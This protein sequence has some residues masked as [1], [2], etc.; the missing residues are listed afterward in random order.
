M[1]IQPPLQQ[2]M[3]ALRAVNLKELERAEELGRD[4][5]FKQAVEFLKKI[6]D[7][8]IQVIENAELLRISANTEQRITNLANNVNE[9]VK[10]IREFVLR[11]NEANAPDQHRQINETVSKLYQED[12]DFLPPLIERVNILK[13]NPSEVEN[14]VAQALQSIKDIEKIKSEAQKTKENIDF[15]VK[16]VRDALGKEGALISATDFENQAEEHKGLAKWWFRASVVSIVITVVLI[17][18]LFSGRFPSLNLT[19]VGNDYPRIAQVTVFK[20]VLLSIAYLL[21]YQSLKN[22]KINQH[23]YVLNKHRQLTLSVYPLMAKATNDQEQ[24]NIIVAQA[25]KAIFDPGTTGYLD[26]DDNPNPVNLT[27]IIN[28]VVDKN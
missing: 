3:D 2:A 6:L 21:V 27:E 1:I 4:Y 11:G 26:G 16:E 12:L 18:T 13:L 24:S 23:L 8:L 7:D 17:L 14:Q 9:N 19:K 28:K 20:L 15:A 25:A 5:S 22:Y 10:K